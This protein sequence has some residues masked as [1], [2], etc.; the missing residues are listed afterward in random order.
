[1]KM[2]SW[3]AKVEMAKLM[4]LVTLLMANF[5]M[6]SVLSMPL[7]HG[8]YKDSCPSA[9]AIVRNAISKAY[10]ADPGVA[11]GL[12]RMH[13]HDCFIRGCDASVLLNSTNG[14]LAEKDSM[15]NYGLSG[16]DIINQV[17]VK[18]EAQCPNT[19][20]CAD[21]ITY[22][23][24]DSIYIAGGIQYAIA[25]GRR[26][27]RFSLAGEVTK[28]LP[29][30][31]FNVQQLKHNFARKGL[32]LEEMVTLSGAHSIGDSHCSNF[33]FRLY[34]YNATHSQDPSLDPS[35][36]N[37]LK[38]KCPMSSK[39]NTS[40]DPLV[41]FDSKTPNRLD[42]NYYK[43]LKQHKGLLASDQVLWVNSNTRKM[44]RNNGNH[45][46]AWAARFAS[47]MVHMGSIQV[48]TGTEGEIRKNCEIVN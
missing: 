20:S 46:S 31:S 37:Y 9:E 4:S 42:N 21:I 26:D 43:N 44:A 2:S 5:L 41:P 36:A 48:L 38:T 45:P 7:K 17:K 8:F 18:I 30:A 47:A 12:I 33:A 10:A 6:Y 1:M 32:S 27:G 19:V 22:A 3:V 15:G 24:R 16:F 13:F 14:N 23:A 40:V 34:S 28:N 35:Y 11:P 29:S 25:G 39:A